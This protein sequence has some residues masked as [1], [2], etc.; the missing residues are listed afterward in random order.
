MELATLGTLPSRVCSSGDFAADLVAIS[1]HS[2]P[3]GP[4]RAPDDWADHPIPAGQLARTPV[5]GE[6]PFRLGQLCFVAPF[7]S[8]SGIPTRPVTDFPTVRESPPV[9]WH[10]FPPVW[11]SPAVMGFPSGA[12]WQGNPKQDDFSQNGGL[13]PHMLGR[14]P[15][16]A[17]T[18]LFRT[19]GSVTAALPTSEHPGELAREECSAVRER[20]TS[21]KPWASKSRFL[22]R[23]Q[24]RH[25]QRH[26]G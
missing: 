25:T 14:R 4:H 21:G 8:G 20:S 10:G 24:P 6:I 5:Y 22:L 1:A 15:R 3:A 26:T 18:H 12:R 23:H 7:P 2:T 16:T 9:L 13:L 17:E 19:R 11:D